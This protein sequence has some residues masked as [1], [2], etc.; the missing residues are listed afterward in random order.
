MNYHRKESIDHSRHY[1]VTILLSRTL[2]VPPLHPQTGWWDW[3]QGDPWIILTGHVTNICG[4]GSAICSEV[5][6]SPASLN[7][8]WNCLHLRTRSFSVSSRWAPSLLAPL[9]GR[10]HTQSPHSAREGE[11]QQPPRHLQVAE[12]GCLPKASRAGSGS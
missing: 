5:S 4:P 10:M 6:Q 3:G 12:N 11:L 7:P 1:R 8:S 9:P 2:P